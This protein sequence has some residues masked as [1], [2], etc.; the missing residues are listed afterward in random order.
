MMTGLTLL[1]IDATRTP[2]GDGNKYS[3]LYDAS[4]HSTDATR[5]PHGDGNSFG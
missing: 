1:A 2:H 5:T 4:S 3:M